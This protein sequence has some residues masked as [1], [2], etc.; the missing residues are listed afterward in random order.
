MQRL[1]VAPMEEWAVPAESAAAGNPRRATVAGL[2]VPSFQC[3]LRRHCLCR[4]WL[5]RRLDRC[6]EPFA[7]SWGDIATLVDLQLLGAGAATQCAGPGRPCRSTL[8]HQSPRP[9]VRELLQALSEGH[10]DRPVLTSSTD[11]PPSRQVTPHTA[12]FKV[13]KHSKLG[14]EAWVLPQP[15]SPRPASLAALEPSRISQKA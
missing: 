10:D 8:G 7:A 1:N 15:D 13:I 14:S 6:K 11:G 4:R 3:C 5:W 12:T 2:C 9:R